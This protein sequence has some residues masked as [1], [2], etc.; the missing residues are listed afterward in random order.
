MDKALVRQEYLKK[1]ESG[2]P[3]F[4]LISAV[5]VPLDFSIHQHTGCKGVGG[6]EILLGSVAQPGVIDWGIVHA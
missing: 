2:R 1:I 3:M 4:K 5:S 6:G